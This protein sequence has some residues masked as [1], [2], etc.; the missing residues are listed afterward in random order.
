MKLNEAYQIAEKLNIIEPRESKDP[1]VKNRARSSVIT[2][3]CVIYTLK[4]RER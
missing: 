4:A 1:T 2:K 3:I